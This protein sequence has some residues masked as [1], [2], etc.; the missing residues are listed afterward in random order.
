MICLQSV[1][2]LPWLNEINFDLEI[3]WQYVFKVILILKVV[4]LL[5]LFVVTFL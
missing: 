1:F 2:D 4:F 3:D 5:A